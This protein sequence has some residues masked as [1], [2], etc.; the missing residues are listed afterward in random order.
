MLTAEQ[1][2][3]IRPYV[4]SLTDNVYAI[5]GLPEEVIAVLFAYVSRSPKSFRENLAK[6]LEDGDIEVGSGTPQAGT[7]ERARKFHEKWVIGYGHNSIAE[8]ATMH[9]GIEKISRVASAALELADPY[10]SFVEYSQRYQR[11]QRG[12]WY[13]P[14]DAPGDLIALYEQAYSA[15]EQSID[16]IKEYLK[17]HSP[18][19]LS[20]HAIEK[21][22]F[23]NARALLPVG[24]YTNLG[25]TGNALAVGRAIAKLSQSPLP[26]VRNLAQDIYKAA[27]FVAPTL[28]RDPKKNLAKG[29]P[30]GAAMDVI[31]K[32]IAPRP[33]EEPRV[34]AERRPNVK[35]LYDSGV[36][37]LDR[38]GLWQALELEAGV[39]DSGFDITMYYEIEQQWEQLLA[40]L[41]PYDQAPRAFRTVWL[42]MEMVLSEAC[43]HQLLRHRAFELFPIDVGGPLFGYICPPLLKEMA[44][45]SVAYSFPAEQLGALNYK[46]QLLYK[47]LADKPH[48]R[49]Y[50]ALNGTAKK[51]HAVTSLWGL[52]HFTRLRTKPE[53]QEEIRSLARQIIE[54]LGDSGDPFYTLMPFFEAPETSKGVA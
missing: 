47:R 13:I 20:D 43:W 42:H 4:S 32:Y 31:R 25:M 27:T 23:E 2:E 8:H 39:P 35:I 53:A 1:M 41:S 3:R 17:R 9:I 15:Y 7:T 38:S 6:I 44:K 45:A 24:M 40:K 48:L 26:E 50:V 11:P 10:L 19:P 36:S 33:E 5:Y 22:A 21:I 51:I 49:P 46:A 29:L 34:L 16:L 18:K 28:V 37:T 12:D 54:Q 52:Y 30:P 14:Q